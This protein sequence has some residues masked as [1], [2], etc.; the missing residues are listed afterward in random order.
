MGLRKTGR[1]VVGI[2]LGRSGTEE[3]WEKGGWVSSGSL[4]G[5]GTWNYLDRNVDGKC[6]YGMVAESPVFRK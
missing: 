5:S 1:R 6:Q 3:D 4:G 2:A